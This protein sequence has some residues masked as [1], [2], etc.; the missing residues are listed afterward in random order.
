[1]HAGGF[2]VGQ[3]YDRDYYIAA[4]S[5]YFIAHLTLHSLSIDPRDKIQKKNFV[6]LDIFCISEP[7]Y[8]VVCDCNPSRTPFWG[9]FE[10]NVFFE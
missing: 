6:V 2:N 9:F 1:M 3:L 8:N 7:K 10:K 5:Y 4:K